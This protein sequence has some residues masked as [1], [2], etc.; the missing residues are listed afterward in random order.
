MASAGWVRLKGFR[1]PMSYRVR[2]RMA[3]LLTLGKVRA[4]YTYYPNSVLI[5]IEFDES[6]M[7]TVLEH[8]RRILREWG[9]QNQ[10]AM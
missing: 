7:E 2:C 6:R 5:R 4:S 8:V 1:F 9:R 10:I 3:R